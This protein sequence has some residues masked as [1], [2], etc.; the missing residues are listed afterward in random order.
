MQPNLFQALYTVAFPALKN[1][2]AMNKL[3]FLDALRITAPNLVSMILVILLKESLSYSTIS[4]VVKNESNTSTTKATDDLG[5]TIDAEREL[6]LLG[7]ATAMSGAVGGMYS[8]PSLG[9]MIIAQGFH[10]ITFRGPGIA[11]I[12]FSIIACVFG[13]NQVAKF[14]PRFCCGGV[15]LQAG[16]K[17]IETQLIAPYSRLPFAEWLV[18]LAIFCSMPILGLLPGVGLG[19]GIS[20]ALLARQYLSVGGI[21]YTCDGTVARSVSERDDDQ[22]D[23]LHDTAQDRHYVSLFGYIFFGNA[24]PLLTYVKFI[25]NHSKNAKAT[26]LV[27][28]LS[29]VTALD[30]SA[31]DVF[32]QLAS[33]SKRF[34]CLLALCGL[35]SHVEREL[36]LGAYQLFEI[37]NIFVDADRAIDAAENFFLK[38]IY[39][40]RTV[41]QDKEIPSLISCLHLAAGRNP[42]LKEIVQRLAPKLTEIARLVRLNPGDRV[43]GDTR[44]GE[45]VQRSLSRTQTSLYFVAKGRVVVERRP[46]HDS[47]ATLASRTV[48][49][50]AHRVAAASR[51][52]LIDDNVPGTE[53]DLY[54][55]RFRIAEY[56]A[57]AVAGIEAF[58]LG[59]Y[60]MTQTVAV[61]PCVLYA[62]SFDDFRALRFTDPGVALD[63]LTLCA[64]RLAKHNDNAYEQLS[65][66]RDA[67]ISPPLT[68]HPAPPSTPIGGTMKAV[69]A[70]SPRSSVTIQEEEEEGDL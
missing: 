8:P 48:L 68:T 57:G 25:L 9:P 45:T 52:R 16:G 70:P 53:Q 64:T 3:F 47:V 21:R 37:A 49:R 15:L 58:C 30:A 40:K 2:F 14:I 66:I 69:P 65:L 1:A 42:Q 38:L 20:L 44:I 62:I 50:R 23:I 39:V 22:D 13:L 43:Q 26:S 55:R 51:R 41:S 24:T 17:L 18:A 32:D 6:R 67:F 11:I 46:G 7:I 4:R 33:T 59:Y 29:F 56:G 35:S 61:S 19:L 12:A 60:S 10:P 31:V 34:G 28:D 36:R 54:D 27:L 5:D 63:L